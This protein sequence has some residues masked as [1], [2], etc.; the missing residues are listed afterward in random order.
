MNSHHY[1]VTISVYYDPLC[2]PEDTTILIPTVIYNWRD[3]TDIFANT[4]AN[5]S[6]HVIKGLKMSDH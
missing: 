5:H 1:N 4:I 6:L 3:N 2:C